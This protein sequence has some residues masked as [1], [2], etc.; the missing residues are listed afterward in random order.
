MGK[1]RQKALNREI[2]LES[3]RAQSSS[4]FLSLRLFRLPLWAYGLILVHL[5][6]RVSKIF[7]TAPEH[8]SSGMVNT[9]NG[10][11]SGPSMF[12]SGGIDGEL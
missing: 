2:Q 6:Y 5:L 8:G 10:Y 4:P 7:S 9:D 3:A 11:A 12:T 1:A